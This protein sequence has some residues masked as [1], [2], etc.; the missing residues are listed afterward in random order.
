[1]D[2]KGPESS[3]NDYAQYVSWSTKSYQESGNV[4]RSMDRTRTNIRVKGPCSQS[5]TIQAVIP[6][7]EESRNI[8]DE[9]LYDFTSKA[10]QLTEAGINIPDELLS[11]MLLGSLPGG[12]ESF[13]VAIESRDEIPSISNL[14][15]K[16]L[17]EGARQTERDGQFDIKKENNTNSEALITKA[18]KQTNL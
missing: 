8:D 9:I 7:E 18:T 15:V 11:I 4:E 5:N 2:E 1:M 13:T 6:D 10:E 17:E 3:G 16:L 12:F 14:K